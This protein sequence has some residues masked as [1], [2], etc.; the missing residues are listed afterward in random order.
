[1]KHVLEVVADRMEEKFKR[2]EK[3]EIARKLK[4]KG[5]SVNDIVET[6]DLTVDDILR[7]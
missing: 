4:A 1:M 5:M 3:K 2:E 6:T 7:L